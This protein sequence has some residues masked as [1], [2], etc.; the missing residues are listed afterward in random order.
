MGLWQFDYEVDT[1]CVPWCLW[2]LRGV[3][4]TDQ[5][6]TLYFRPFTQITGLDIDAD[7]T[8]HLGPL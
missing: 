6:S 1:D 4:L 8:G 2:C 3:E 7:V 5:S